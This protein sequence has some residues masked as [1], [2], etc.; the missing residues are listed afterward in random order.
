MA[1]TLLCEIVTPESILYTNEV[2]MVVASTPAGEVGILPLHTPIVTTLAPGEVRLR[3]GDS[4]ADWEF[5][6]ISGGYL[7]VHEDKVIILADAAVS[8]SQ[9]DSS[10]SKESKELIEARLAELP[11][12]AAD[13]RAE[14]IRDLSW[15]E[16]QLK[17]VEKRG[18]K[19]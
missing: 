7:Q 12:D 13:E 1:R 2:Q 19:R 6:S 9:I 8:V 17:A 15:H 16:I 18:G 11:E 3:F 14:M 10:R 4:A 5:F